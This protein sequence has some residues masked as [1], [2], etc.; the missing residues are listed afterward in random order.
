MTASSGSFRFD[1]RE[2]ALADFAL[3]LNA[4][5]T[6]HPE[7]YT[8]DMACRFVIAEVLDADIAGCTRFDAQLVG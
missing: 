7:V 5:Q 3:C 1:V 6:D 2:L 4:V 8:D